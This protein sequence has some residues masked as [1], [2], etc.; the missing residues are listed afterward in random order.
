MLQNKDITN[1]RIHKQNELRLGAFGVV[2]FF[3]KTTPA[4]HIS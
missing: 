2:L 4:K 1:I 3:S